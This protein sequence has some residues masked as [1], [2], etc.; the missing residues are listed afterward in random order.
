MSLAITGAVD[1]WGDL[2]PDAARN[3][4][5]DSVALARLRRCTTVAE[6][7]LDPATLMLYWRCGGI[8]PQDLPLGGLTAAVLAHV[9]KDDTERRS[10]AR[11][12][13]PDSTDRP[14][15]ALLKPAR[16]R[17]LIEADTPD[18]RLTSF[19]GLVV[20]AGGKLNVRDLAAA[21]LTWTEDRRTQWIYDYW[22]AGEPMTSS[23]FEGTGL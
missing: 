9:R 7:M 3:H 13:G 12:I 21:L 8:G 1:W 23:Q 10:V 14:G 20:L 16:F 5:G 2:Q 17:R 4:L 11:A 22:N 15:T 18:E 19:R 6:A